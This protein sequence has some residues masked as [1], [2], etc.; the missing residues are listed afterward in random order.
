MKK[1]T[2]F[3]TTFFEVLKA[4]FTLGISHI[5]KRKERIDNENI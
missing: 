2:N 4:I 5:N 1:N 3:W